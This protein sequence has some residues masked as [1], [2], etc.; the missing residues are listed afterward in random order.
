MSERYSHDFYDR[1]TGKLIADYVYANKRTVAAIR[2]AQRWIPENSRRILDIGCGIGWTSS[3]IKKEHPSANVLGIDLSAN[4]ISTAHKLFSQDNLEFHQQNIVDWNPAEL[5]PFDAILL[6][7]VYEHIKKEDR[8]KIHKAIQSALSK[9]GTLILSFPSVAHQHYLR[10]HSPL[11]LQPVDE[12]VTEEDISIFA[13]D[14]D[15][16]ILQFEYVDIWNPKD[17]VHVTLSR[18][19]NLKR[20][21]IMDN[22]ESSEE[23][24]ERV[25]KSLNHRITPD[26][27]VL[28]IVSNDRALCLIAPTSNQYSETFI[29][30]HA[31]R[32]PITIRFLHGDA[33]QFVLDDGEPLLPSQ[34]LKT[35]VVRHAMRRGLGLSEN[36]FAERAF[37]NFL[38]HSK[39]AVVLAEYGPTGVSVMD[40]CRKANIP[41]IVHFHGYDA[42]V[43]A[44]IN[45]N[46]KT[47]RE[48][49]KQCAAI[50]VVSQ[51]MAGQLISLGAPEEK[52]HLNSCGVDISLFNGSK[53]EDMPPLFA[54][55]GRFV[56]KKGPQLTLL[57]F[58]KVLHSCPDARLVMVGDGPLLES[59]KQLSSSLNMDTAVTFTGAITHEMIAE[60]FRKLRGF[61]QHSVRTSSG[62]MEGTPVSIL[63]AGASGLPVVSTRHGG[64]K[65]AVLHDQTGF[66]VEEGDIEMMAQYISKLATDPYVAAKMGSAARVHIASNY[67]MEKSINGLWGIIEKAIKKQTR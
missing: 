66:L 32:L 39:I 27:I 38:D 30:S 11:G 13:N 8:T 45:E 49:F 46:S 47:Y 33:Y 15:S 64:I 65:E 62:D 40:A 2:H 24:A 53:P 28:P 52:I 16:N 54:S 44:V 12:D 55:V 41:L 4:L 51:D 57:A 34:S 23:R 60:L 18:N 10:N 50:V 14:T 58:E 17:Y 9:D 22:S 20:R 56:D 5:H 1:F 42:Y 25:R 31:E 6:L 21:S 36:H 19:T 67:S 61:V 48:M 37:L 43:Q 29:R 35:R 3:S 63:E 26:G 59:S 7:D